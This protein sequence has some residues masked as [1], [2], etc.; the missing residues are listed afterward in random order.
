MLCFYHSSCLN[1]TVAL[2]DCQVEECASR[3]QHVYKGEYVA[4]NEINLDGAE[5][6]IFRNFVDDLWMG[7]KPEKLKKAG[8]STV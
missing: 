2:A 5:Q 4:M 8:H 3:L 7:G 1:L 6:N